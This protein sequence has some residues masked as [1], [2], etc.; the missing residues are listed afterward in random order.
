[1]IRFSLSIEPNI[2]LHVAAC[3]NNS[4]TIERLLTRDRNVDAR[5]PVFNATALHYA[6]ERGNLEAVRVLL[7][8]GADLQATTK[9]K[10]TPLHLAAQQRRKAVCKLL[11]ERGANASVR[12]SEGWTPLH[13][14]C[15][16]AF[17]ADIASLMIDKGAD[18]NAIMNDGRSGLHL[19][20]EET[21]SKSPDQ[22]KICQ[23]LIEK[24]CRVDMKDYRNWTALH[25]GAYDGQFE[26]CKILVANKAD[27]MALTAKKN[28]PL[29]FAVDHNHY[30]IVEL[31]LDNGAD[32]NAQD[33][34]RWTP[35][36][37]AAEDNH[38]AIAE[39]LIEVYN[40]DP[41]LEDDCGRSPLILAAYKSNFAVA[42][43]LVSSSNC[44]DI[45]AALPENGATALH[46]ATQINNPAL[47]KALL[48]RGAYHDIALEPPMSLTP[49][50]IA[51]KL[52]RLPVARILGQVEE[53]F[54]A[55][56]GNNFKKVQSLIDKGALVNAREFS[57]GKSALH[58]AIDNGSSELVR[59]LLCKG[60]RVDLESKEGHTSLH[61]TLIG[62]KYELTVLLIKHA[63]TKLNFEYLNSFLDAKTAGGETALHLAVK[64]T[65]ADIVK[66]LIQSGAKYNMRNGNGS[67]PADVATGDLK[68]YF[69]VIDDLF[70]HAS[71]G[72]DSQ[73]LALLDQ[74]PTVIN[75]RDC[76]IGAT[77]LYE[78]L[79]KNRISAARNMLERGANV[80]LVTDKGNTV[81]HIASLRGIFELVDDLIEKCPVANKK[82][83][84]NFKTFNGRNTALHVATNEDFVRKMRENGA[85]SR[86]K[87]S[88]GKTAIDVAPNESVKKLLE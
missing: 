45:N 19:I 36:H 79:S 32:V 66:L 4:S 10:F 23:V 50:Q 5:E 2:P 54:T 44:V 87:N 63:E 14:V 30:E 61:A 55:V 24:G 72:S 41:C 76:R 86:M 26:V 46:L 81:L 7:D 42:A 75:A 9:H 88:K 64:S 13:N 35:L 43:K 38:F 17:S 18:V 85:D 16:S 71:S 74:E 57:S 12:D 25:C 48:D 83:F 73:L 69:E 29:H 8:K 11:L 62:E 39:L 49:I 22:S 52:K 6:S 34:D 65:K 67:T 58:Y 47:V 82:D 1:M 59:Y 70:S 68:H 80:C 33:C 56:K 28:T 21:A 51:D 31:L 15:Q 53:V 3:L 40:A 37:Y 60:A 77:A 84:V 27:V 78:A 20:A